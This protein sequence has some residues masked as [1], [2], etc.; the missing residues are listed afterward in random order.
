MGA[1]RHFTLAPAN[2]RPQKSRVGGTGATAC[3]SFIF[4]HGA[5][6]FGSARSNDGTELWPGSDGALAPAWEGPGRGAYP[7]PN[8]AAPGCSLALAASLAGQPAIQHRGPIWPRGTSTPSMTTAWYSICCGWPWSQNA[9]VGSRRRMRSMFS[10]LRRP[11][12]EAVT[13]RHCRTATA[14]GQRSLAA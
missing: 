5:K 8:P 13:S 12:G 3:L 6:I 9:P 10:M 1:G 2:G 11:C 4:L 7:A 14:S